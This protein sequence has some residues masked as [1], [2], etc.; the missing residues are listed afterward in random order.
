MKNDFEDRGFIGSYFKIQMKRM[1]RLLPSVAGV[2][3]ALGCVVILMAGVFSRDAQ[4]SP[5][6]SKYVLGIVGNPD[7]NYLGFGIS[8]L[9]SLDDS[10]FMI[11]FVR[12]DEKDALRRLRRGEISGY[13]VVPD[14]LVDSLM[15][16]VSD[17]PIALFGPEG[18]KGISSIKNSLPVKWRGEN[19]YL[20]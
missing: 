20:P 15:A 5:E 19:F 17:R 6:K 1:L 11:D 4:Q 9:S 16:G 2:A 13:I 12:L 8:A 10:R 7:E 18:Q 14:G 3:A